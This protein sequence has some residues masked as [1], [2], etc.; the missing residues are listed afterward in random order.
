MTMAVKNVVYLD[1]LDAAHD[2]QIEDE[3][4]YERAINAECERIAGEPKEVMDIVG[5]LGDDAWLMIG[6]ALGCLANSIGSKRGP[7]ID[8][9][10]AMDQ[11]GVMMASAIVYKAQRNLAGRTN[12]R[13]N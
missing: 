7:A 13:L 8:D 6:R 12:E 10:I 11:A 2:Q 5:D 1:K 3:A 9:V 4:A